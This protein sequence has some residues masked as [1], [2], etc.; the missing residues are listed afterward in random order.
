MPVFDQSFE[1]RIHTDDDGDEHLMLSMSGSVVA[2]ESRSARYRISSNVLHPYEYWVLELTSGGKE[3]GT[4]LLLCQHEESG[5]GIMDHS[6]EDRELFPPYDPAKTLTREQIFAENLKEEIFQLTDE[7]CLCDTQVS[8]YHAHWV[9]QL[10]YHNLGPFYVADALLLA[11]RL[12]EDEVP[13]EYFI[14]VEEEWQ[15]VSW[16]QLQQTGAREICTIMIPRE[17]MGT[18][19]Y[20]ED[21]AF[22]KGTLYYHESDSGEDGWH[23]E[24]THEEVEILET[25]SKLEYEKADLER[26]KAALLGE[27]EAVEREIMDPEANWRMNA[28]QQAQR[29]NRQRLGQIEWR[30]QGVEKCIEEIP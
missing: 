4:V 11:P 10:F 2:G 29:E 8:G 7:I 23:D 20:H 30:L 22:P 5:Y 1:E 3:R 19:S 18:A 27:I 15:P 6:E 14:E 25:L 13:C 17:H 16:E 21:K 24:A 12:Q 26:Q 28:L 9:S